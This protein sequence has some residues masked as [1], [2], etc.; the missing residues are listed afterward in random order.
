VPRECGG[1]ELLLRYAHGGGRERLDDAEPLPT[2]CE[3]SA[4]VKKAVV[5]QIA[6]CAIAMPATPHFYPKWFYRP[7]VP[8]Q[9]RASDL[10]RG[11][12]TPQARLA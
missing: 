3:R 5:D 12:P 10:A 7:N 11:I 2:D 9:I 8:S 6:H 1:T 4:F